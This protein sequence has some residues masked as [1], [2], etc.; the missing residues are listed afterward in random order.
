MDQAML[1]S[2]GA[3]FLGARIALPCGNGDR[4]FNRLMYG[5]ADRNPFG[6]ACSR[7]CS[8]GLFYTPFSYAH[9]PA[10][11]MAAVLYCFYPAPLEPVF[12]LLGKRSSGRVSS[13]R[14]VLATCLDQRAHLA[15]G[16][17]DIKQLCEA[18]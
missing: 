18:L 12:F 11:F 3:Y 9:S 2:V 1:D 10:A 4:F 7:F 16:I 15:L 8:D 14:A 13:R 6:G 17:Y 5:F